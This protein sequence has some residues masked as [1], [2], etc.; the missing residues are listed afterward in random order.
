M[1]EKYFLPR[2]HI[3]LSCELE[4]SRRRRGSDCGHD[5]ACAC[6]ARTPGLDEASEPPWSERKLRRLRGEIWATAGTGAATKQDKIATGDE[7][8]APDPGKEPRRPEARRSALM[9]PD[10]TP[11]NRRS[12]LPDA[13]CGG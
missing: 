9:P 4:P 6:V 5:G 10:T 8:D 7:L 13:T 11:S 12:V 2:S 1:Q 3:G